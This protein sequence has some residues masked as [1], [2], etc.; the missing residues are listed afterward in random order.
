MT[1]A[2][3]FDATQFSFNGTPAQ[4]A[5]C[6]LRFVKRGG[7]VGDANATLPAALADL[8]AD[9][10]ALGVTSAQL[11]LNLQNRGI[12]ESTVG[13]SVSE[14]V[15]HADSDNPAAPLARYFVIHD[16]SKKLN[17]GQTFDPALIDSPTWRGNQLAYLAR[18]K[19]HVYI[20][21]LGQTLTDNAY[22]TPWRATQFEKK[23]TRYRGLFLHHELV[24]PR[25]GPGKSDIESPDPGFTPAQYERL[26]LQ[27]V[28]AS[29]RRGSWMIPVF[30]CVL[31]L[32]VGDHD[33]PQHFDLAAW[34]QALKATLREVKSHNI[35]AFRAVTAL[36]AADAAAD[37]KTPPAKS[38]TKDGK[39]GSTTTGLQG[40]IYEPAP[41]VKVID[42]TETLTAFRNRHAL[43]PPRTVRQVRTA[44][45]G[46]SVIE[47]PDYCWGK[48]TLPSAELVENHAG[49]GQ[50]SGI[51]EG[52]A[53][54]FGKSDTEDEGTGAPAFGT[55][56]TDSSVFGIALKKARLISEGLATEDANRVLHP[57]E[58]GLRAIVEVYFPDTSRLVRLPLVDVGPGTT[59]PAKTAVAD[60]TV[61]ATAFLQK[62]T[63]R[64]I[65]KLDNIRV[66]ARIVA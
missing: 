47:Q 38:A 37:F 59:G 19:T 41:G 9:P 51:F 26:A 35:D 4:Q 55:V 5:S 28:I 6:L 10:Q 45:A 31:D 29:V 60:L 30:H 64:D 21:R 25:M 62:L 44:K 2:C 57:T 65:K 58:K 61:A 43:G 32:H 13:G 14:R 50:G 42:A 33:D 48:R 18:G 12:V 52:K 3:A 54:Y 40:K 36:A 24:Q 27:Y 11:R 56:Q 20:T 39:S 53:T 17:P 22:T 49:F 66:H 8:L 34:G 23:T 46:T 1:A 16:T 7:E 63:E 15:C